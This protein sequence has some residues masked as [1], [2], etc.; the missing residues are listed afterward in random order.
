LNIIK[1][2]KKLECL[3]NFF[4]L[5]KIVFIC[6]GLLGICRY[7]HGNRERAKPDRVD[8]TPPGDSMRLQF[9]SEWDLLT[10]SPGVLAQL[11]GADPNWRIPPQDKACRRDDFTHMWSAAKL[12]R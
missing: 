9:P 10:R 7:F 6:G 5:W 12:A 2:T 3:P 8:L 11:E 4:F 1:Y